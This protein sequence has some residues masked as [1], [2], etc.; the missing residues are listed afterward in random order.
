[1]LKINFVNI[2]A[3]DSYNILKDKFCVTCSYT[4]SN[5]NLYFYT[6]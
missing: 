4:N 5:K 1:M 2:K 6:L 3:Y